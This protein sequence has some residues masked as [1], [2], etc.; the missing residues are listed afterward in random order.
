MIA[1][2]LLRKAIV[3]VLL[4][5]AVF[6]AG[7]AVYQSGAANERADQLEGQVERVEEIT[8][9]IRDARQE[10]RRANPTGDAAIARQRLLDRQQSR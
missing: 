5:V 8:G 1:L 2:G 4:G 3:P 6:L 7:Y 10:V 9:A